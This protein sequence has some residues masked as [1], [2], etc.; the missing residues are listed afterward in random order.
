MTDK[1]IDQKTQYVITGII[2]ILISLG[3][4]GLNGTFNESADALANY[5]I[6]DV[7]Q[8]IGE[9]ARLSSTL[10][11]AY[12]NEFDSK[13]YDRCTDGTNKGTWYGLLAYAEANGL[14]LN[15]LIDTTEPVDPVDPID[16]VVP[17]GEGEQYE[18][19]NSGC[20][21]I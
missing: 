12:P 13:G 7:T 6:C 8:D 16:P 19:S 20:V 17:S 1:P 14:D 9:Y 4:A 18:C 3:G 11:T 21:L 2:A 15:D 10:Y 5:Y